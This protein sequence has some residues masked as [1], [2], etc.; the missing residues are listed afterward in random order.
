MATFLICAK[1]GQRNTPDTQFCTNCKTYLPW[2][3]AP[4]TGGQTASPDPPPPPP[5]PD[6]PQPPPPPPDPPPPPPPDRPAG[7]TCPSCGQVNEPGRN[8]CANCGQLLARRQPDM[9]PTRS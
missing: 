7:P 6:P 2:E 1:C 5:P 9:L 8:F 4:G 3:N